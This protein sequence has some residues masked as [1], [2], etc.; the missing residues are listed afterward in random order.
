MWTNNHLVQRCRLAAT[1]EPVGLS[2]FTHR[3]PIIAL[4]CTFWRGAW[5][6]LSHGTLTRWI[7]CEI[8][9]NLWQRN[10]ISVH[11]DG[12]CSVLFNYTVSLAQPVSK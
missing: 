5:C 11:H 4:G 10:W 2:A 7:L 1:A 9:W 8:C 6:F 12:F 3:T